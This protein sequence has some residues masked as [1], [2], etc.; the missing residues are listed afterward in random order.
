M[1]P[2]DI[3]V[4]RWNRVFFSAALPMT[5]FGS[6]FAQEMV[7]SLY[8]RQKT[9]CLV[10]YPNPGG[11]VS[12]DTTDVHRQCFQGCMI[13]DIHNGLLRRLVSEMP[14]EVEGEMGT[15]L[16]AVLGRY[17]FHFKITKYVRSVEYD[18]ERIDDPNLAG[19]D[20]VLG[21]FAELTVT[22]VR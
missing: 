5:M 18:Y 2:R 10:D 12:I 21:R 9:L 16:N 15:E 17:Q 14:R 22:I 1:N 19:E 6:E 8:T 11:Y 4:A 20:E 7:N 3:E 13:K